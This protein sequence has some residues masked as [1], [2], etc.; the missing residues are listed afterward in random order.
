[1][2][3]KWGIPCSDGQ[4][5]LGSVTYEVWPFSRRDRPRSAL[6]LASVIFKQEGRALGN[7]LYC[8]FRAPRDSQ[9]PSLLVGWGPKR[10]RT[11]NEEWVLVARLS[12]E[13]PANGLYLLNSGLRHISFVGN[14]NVK[15]SLLLISQHRKD[16]VSSLTNQV[17][18]KVIGRLLFDHCLWPRFL[19]TCSA[20]YRL[21]FCKNVGSTPPFSS[22]KC[23]KI[24]R[25]NGNGFGKSCFVL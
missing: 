19:E 1:M 24:W 7:H 2:C 20:H 18:A 17:T 12:L 9:R 5:L 10:H 11:W 23:Q 16:I 8:S 13:I 6:L 25:K 22:F 15:K 3:Q 21:L 14:W 4:V